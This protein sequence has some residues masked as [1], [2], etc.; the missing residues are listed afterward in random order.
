MQYM[1]GSSTARKIAAAGV[2]AAFA[3]GSALLAVPAGAASGNVI[4]VCTTPVGDKEFVT[5]ADTNLPATLTAGQSVPVTI[6]ASVTIPA[7]LSELAYGFLGARTVEGTAVVK[8]KLNGAALPDINASVPSVPVPASGPVTVVATGAGPAFAPTAAGN[9][10]FSM[11]TY[12][13]SLSFK[14]EDGVEAIKVDTSCTPKVVGPAQNLSVDSVTVAA[15]PTTTPPPAVVKVASTSTVKA[16]YTAKSDKIVAK[17]A[18]KGADGKP[19]TGKVKVTLKLGKKAKTV[20]ATLNA[21]GK[22]L[23]VFKKITKPGK[24]KIT[25]AYAG[26]DTQNASTAKTVLKIK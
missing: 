26:S 7:D 23:A 1:L 22:A 10:V 19:G 8:S 17:V 15:A 12:T 4:F 25:V 21:Q 20:S 6:T 9:Y 3:A 14:K 24:Y 13:A 18:V 5:V 2:T 11:D 16:K